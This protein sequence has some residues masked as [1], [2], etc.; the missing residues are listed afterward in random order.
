MFKSIF[1]IVALLQFITLVVGIPNP[2]TEPHFYKYNANYTIVL[3]ANSIP[4]PGNFTLRSSLYDTQGGAH[5]TG[6]QTTDG[7]IEKSNY[8]DDTSAHG[9]WIIPESAL[10]KDIGFFIIGHSE[11]SYFN[12]TIEL[13]AIGVCNYSGTS[14]SFSRSI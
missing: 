7:L 4:A 8:V 6:I 13:S 2:I 10:D 5:L 3:P 11:G 12:Q 1:S 14:V 9:F